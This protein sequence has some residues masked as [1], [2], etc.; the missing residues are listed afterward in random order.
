[1]T[2]DLPAAQSISESICSDSATQPPLHILALFVLARAHLAR[3]AIEP[4]VAA[5]REVMRRLAS[6]PIK[7]WEEPVRLTLVECFFA[8]GWDTDGNR[9]LGDAFASVAA[10]ARSLN[11][12][13]YRRAYLT[14]NPD[15]C[16][17]LHL[18]GRRLNCS[19]PEELDS[20]AC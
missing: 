11:L 13:V 5:A 17:I 19:L 14:R 18:A 12:P 2:D 10:R 3:G 15:V 7:E 4:A 20:P 16:A 8:L 9:I 1:M 6:T